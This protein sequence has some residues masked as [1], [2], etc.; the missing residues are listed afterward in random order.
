MIEDKEL[1]LKVA[2]NPREA[3]IKE[4]IS[5]VEK[6]IVGLELELELKRDGLRYLKTLQ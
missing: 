6:S 5:N 4:T 3:L 2:E 1:G